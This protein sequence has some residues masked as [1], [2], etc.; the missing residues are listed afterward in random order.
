MVRISEINS[1][2]P[3]WSQGEAFV[4]YD[5][6]LERARPIFFGRRRINLEKGDIAILRGP[7]QVGKTTY[8]KDTV[9]RLLKKGVPAR[10]ILYLSLDFFTSR[11]EMRNAINYFRESRRDASHIYLLLDEI[12]TLEDWNLELK[13]MADLGLL[14]KG[15]ILATGSNAIKLKQKT[16][17]L[18]GR[19]LEGNEYFVKPLN[20]RDFVLR[21]IDY[22]SQH[23]SDKEFV[24]N[25]K[26]L[27]LALSDVSIDLNS[28]LKE[29]LSKFETILPYKG[30]LG[31][32]F[33]LYLTTGGLPGVVNHY[34]KN[35]FEAHKDEMNQ[36]IAEIYIRDILGDLNRL[37]KQE[38]ITRQLLKAI[39]ERYSSRYSFSKLSRQIERTHVTTIDYL[40][41]MEDS[42]I[43]FVHYAYDF[44][45]KDVKA[46]G[47]KKVY[48]FDPF[49]LHTARSYL[50]GTGVWDV[51]RKS[52]DDDRSIGKLVEG[53]VISHLR[54]Y[55]EI[56]LL[57]KGHTFLWFYYDKSKKELDAIMKSNSQILGFEIKF[58][59]Q[60]ESKTIKRIDPVKKC[61]LLTKDNVGI[62]DDLIMIPTDVFLSLLPKSDKNL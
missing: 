10:N 55:G 59:S 29:M 48:F 49:I 56:P 3:W 15:S 47:D 45:K 46:K 13:T 36:S 19:G 53:T 1:Q 30:E 61:I 26:R 20:F 14:K 42:F 50:E 9:I 52:Q 23:I 41:Y 7:R 27:Q 35:R 31:F 44:N 33:Q 58:Q 43:C 2:N 51:I 18:P 38:S 6:T 21:S 28:D 4:Q 37:Q 17:L 39:I 22:L 11:R 12:T 34:L 24:S 16:E 60:V 54:S 62:E 5:K 25:L 8:I 32:L 40:Q 57:K